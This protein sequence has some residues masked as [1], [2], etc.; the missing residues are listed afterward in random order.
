MFASK[1]FRFILIKCA[2]RNARTH[3]VQHILG[4][5][6]SLINILQVSVLVLFWWIRFIGVLGAPAT[7]TSLINGKNN[8]NYCFK[9]YC[10]FSLPQLPNGV[11]AASV[12]C[13]VSVAFVFRIFSSSSFSCMTLIRNKMKSSTINSCKFHQYIYIY[14]LVGLSLV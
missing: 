12:Q 13:S 6:R 9:I 1:I 5:S 11:S 10:I 4:L 8:Q 14:L 7:H 2:L 3:H